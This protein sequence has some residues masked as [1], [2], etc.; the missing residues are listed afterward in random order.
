MEEQLNK[1]N[2]L[3][4]HT[5]NLFESGKITQQDIVDL[6]QELQRANHNI[7][8]I[9]RGN[10]NPAG[11]YSAT[12]VGMLLGFIWVCTRFPRKSP[13]SIRL[14]VGSVPIAIYG[15]VFFKFGKWRFSNDDDAKKNLA[16]LEQSFSVDDEFNKLVK[17][18]KH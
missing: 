16:F 8:H 18:F 12:A 7:R 1:K 4:K 11:R 9:I 15:Y 5:K 13:L 17:S 2:D 14:L 6:N 3:L 10:M